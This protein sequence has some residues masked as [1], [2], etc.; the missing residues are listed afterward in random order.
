MSGGTIFTGEYCPPGHY[1]PVNIVP[2]G[3]NSLV[4]IVPLGGYCPP[5]TI[6]TSEKCPPLQFIYRQLNLV[7]VFRISL[8]CSSGGGTKFTGEKCPP[9][10]IECRQLTTYYSLAKCVC[11]FYIYMVLVSLTNVASA[12]SYIATNTNSVR[13]NEHHTLLDVVLH[14]YCQVPGFTDQ[15][16]GLCKKGGGG[17]GGHYSLVN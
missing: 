15:N 9:L 14:A 8:Y 10:Q 17:G 1:S 5:R 4:N 13:R 2:L 3:Q 6:F 11:Y 7:I 16:L 12:H